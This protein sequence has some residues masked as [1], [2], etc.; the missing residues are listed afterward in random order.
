MCGNRSLRHLLIVLA[1]LPALLSAQPAPAAKP[2][3]GGGGG[4]GGHWP[5]WRGPRRDNVSDEAGLIR[6]WPEGGPPLLWKAKGLGPGYASVSV[7]D[8][9][10]YTMGDGPD[11]AYV[12]VLDEATG[13]LVWSAKVG[14]PGGGN[15]YPGPR[16][17][18]TIDRDLAGGGASAPR[19]GRLSAVG[20]H[21]DLVCLRIEDGKEVWRKHMVKDFKGLMVG[22]DL[23]GNPIPPWGYTE[24]PLVDGDKLICTPGGPEGTLAA[25]DKHTGEVIWRSKEWTD[26]AVYPSVQVVEI[27]GRRQYLQLTGERLGGV[28]AAT[29]RVLWR[30]PRK[31]GTAVVATPAYQDNLVFTTSG[32]GA[33]CH[34]FRI[35]ADGQGTDATFRAEL[36]YSG[37][38]MNNHLGGIVLVGGYV[39][40]SDDPGILKCIEF[41]TGKVMWKDRSVGKGS[42]TYADGHIYLRSQDEEGAVALVEAT[43][44]GYR[45]KGRL[46]Q[47]D[48]SDRNTWPPPVVA[49]GRLYLRDQDVL[50]C[51][52]VRA[53]RR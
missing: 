16:C 3:S 30:A 31:G 10:V 21:G 47:P 4:D 34:V 17:T 50:L 8:G 28:D 20:Q 27:A 9:R 2:A 25:L 12:R 5:Q 39:Y 43:P 6:S 26:P 41:K 36:A 42:V 32:Y 48:R 45:E 1:S 15:G 29:G 33:G 19:G 13:Q 52:E 51:Y 18:P 49:G 37:Q 22:T 7:A 24:S 11:A 53:K 44:D 38:Q 46:D 14:P 35:T 23:Q 40:G